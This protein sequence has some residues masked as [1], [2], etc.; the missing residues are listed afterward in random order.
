MCHYVDTILSQLTFDTPVNTMLLSFAEV[1]ITNAQLLTLFNSI[2]SDC[3]TPTIKLT[4]DPPDSLIPM[5]NKSRFYF[6]LVT[7]TAL[8]MVCVIS[9]FA[10]VLDFALA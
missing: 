6:H 10:F 3:F 2:H 4:H 5:W 9:F 7:C 8:V 1:V